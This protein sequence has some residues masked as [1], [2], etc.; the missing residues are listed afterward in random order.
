MQQSST[1][2]KLSD[3]P[4]S[5]IILVVIGVISLFIVALFVVFALI[6]PFNDG[7]GVRKSD[8]F[9]DY[10]TFLGAIC[11]IIL[12]ILNAY[13][14]FVTYK[15][16]QKQ[17]YEATRQYHESNNREMRFFKRERFENR[18]FE[19]M[20]AN[21]EI[22]IQMRYEVPDEYIPVEKTERH[23]NANKHEIILI[24]GQRVFVQIYKHIN[25]AVEECEWIKSLYPDASVM[26]A[27]K[28][29]H[30]KEK[31]TLE[32]YYKYVG[33]EVTSEVITQIQWNNIIYCCIF[34]G[35]SQDGERVLRR[36]LQ[37]SYKIDLVDKVILTLKAKPAVWSNYWSQYEQLKESGFKE[38]A[39]GNKPG[40]NHEKYNKFY[41]GHQHRLGHYY[42]NLFAIYNFLDD[43]KELSWDDKYSY[44]KQFRSQ[45]ST[46]EQAL[47][48][49]NSLSSLGR[50]WEIEAGKHIKLETELCHKLLIT[51]YDLVKNVPAEFTSPTNLDVYYPLVNYEL[52]AMPSKKKLF[53][54]QYRQANPEDTILDKGI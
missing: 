28:E 32:A 34:F 20:R 15:A 29:A 48:V 25:L 40:H 5:R 6:K 41:G 16:Q 26:F 24:E 43:H 7:S 33:K 27:T 14:I 11:G 47:F 12:S 46:Y 49:F 50:S 17:V 45:F 51:K 19:M 39:S 30:Q 36:H 3:Q 13:L 54:A 4:N 53:I 31:Q 22:V 38:I 44:A 42:R 18:F 52:S 23:E 2:K 10:A 37:T 21:R 8:V 35:L 9:S 1:D